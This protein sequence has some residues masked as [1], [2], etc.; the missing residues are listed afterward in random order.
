MMPPKKGARAEAKSVI[1]PHEEG[2]R[3]SSVNPSN[4]RVSRPKLPPEMSQLEADAPS[5]HELAT[6]A[7]ASAKPPKPPS[8]LLVIA[9]A[10]AGA[11][12]VVA[13]S[14]SVAW[15]ARHYV[16]TTPR[17][18]VREIAVTGQSRRSVD[19]IAT[20]AGIARGANVFTVDLD[21]A[22]AKLL[23]DPWI[24]EAFLARRLPGTIF[25][26]VTE[27]EAAAIVALGDSY[28]ATR[29]GE[30]FKRLEPGDPADSPIITGLTPDA[31]AED[32][33]G[34]ARSIRRALDLAADYE[35]SPLGT[36]APLQEIHYSSDGAIT[37]IVGKSALALNLGDPPF[38]KKLEQAARVLTELD[39]RG[40]KPD[41][42][43]LDN[44]ARPERVVVRVR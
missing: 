7:D 11:A 10:V 27:R 30:I 26:Q 22:R 31:V 4:R 43:M 42:I 36:R 5:D 35:S 39:R 33:E 1:D 9:R 6:D 24:S 28:L 3:P 13:V 16:M 14:I 18:A 34:V 40:A 21:G 32:R 15:A 25:V 8:R 2:R 12:L 37:I 44:E 17:F 38:R 23:A 29:E 19:D 20:E 41:A